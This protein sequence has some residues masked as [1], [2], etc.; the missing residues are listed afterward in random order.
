MLKLFA[1]VGSCSMLAMVGCGEN[2]SGDGREVTLDEETGQYAVE[3]AASGTVWLACAV[4]AKWNT[5]SQQCDGEPA[6]I[7][8]KVGIQSCPTG[9]SLPSR[10]DYVAVMCDHLGAKNRICPNDQYTKC[11]DCAA[12]RAVF[13]SHTGVYLTDG[14]DEG[15]AWIGE[16]VNLGT[17]CIT[18]D[19]YYPEDDYS[20]HCVKSL[21]P[22]ASVE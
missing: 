9:F 7:S 18:S 15:D 20:F 10:E 16:E 17:G 14:Y 1:L 11:R 22:D 12:C 21:E 13:S 19:G 6:E 3:D 2:N 8:Y 5:D 4:G